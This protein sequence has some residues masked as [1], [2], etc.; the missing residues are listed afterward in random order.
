MKSG[1]VLL[2]KVKLDE[3]EAVLKE[4][5]ASLE[6]GFIIPQGGRLY[7]TSRRLIFI[8][9]KWSLSPNRL[10]TVVIDLSQVSAAEKK[11]GDMSNLLAGSFRK[12][13]H[14]RAGDRSYLFQVWGLDGWLEQIKE[15]I[16]SLGK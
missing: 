4:S 14:I 3:G 2:G 9:G 7:L 16:K 13:L 10:E 5:R 8:P 6:T 12:R 11:K 1:N 15:I